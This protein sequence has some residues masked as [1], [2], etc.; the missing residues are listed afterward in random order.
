MSASRKLYI[1]LAKRFK[2][3]RPLSHTNEYLTWKVMVLVVANTLKDDNSGFHTQK[4]LVA[5]GFTAED[6]AAVLTP[7]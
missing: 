3:H 5:C 1:N 6:V 4:F 7:A 2:L